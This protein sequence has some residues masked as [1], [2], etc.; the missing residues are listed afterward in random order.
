MPSPILIP[1]N[2]S[3]SHYDATNEGGQ[4]HPVFPA[5]WYTVPVPVTARSKASVCGHSLAGI[6]CSNLTGGMDVSLLLSVVCCQA[7]V[8]A[9]G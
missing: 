4:K 2:P 3:I 9:S 6:A 7:E 8:S 1:S 5:V